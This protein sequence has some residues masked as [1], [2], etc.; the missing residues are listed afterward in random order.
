MKIQA[1][2]FSRACQGHHFNGDFAFTREQEDGL[3]FGL[4]DGAGHGRPA[5]DIA[6][7][8]KNT[9]AASGSDDLSA[10]VAAVHK[11]LKGT[12]GAVGIVGFVDGTRQRLN[13]LGVGDCHARLYGDRSRSLTLRPGSL[14]NAL[15]ELEESNYAISPGDLICVCSDGISERYDLRDIKQYRV[16]TPAQLARTLVHTVGKAH[17]DATALVL[18][19]RDA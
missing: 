14:G 17:D 7:K 8:I 12:A 18:R 3:Y 10:A 15:P 6:L 5:R 9:L 19:V 13:I 2:H 1:G 4:F 11:A 16:A